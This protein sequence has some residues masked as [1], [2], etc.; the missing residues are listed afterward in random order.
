MN[1]VRLKMNNS[2]LEFIIFGNKTQV[3]KCT[4]EG[5]RIDGEI[6]SRSQIMKYLG[7]CM[8]SELFIKT[9]VKEKCTSAMLNLQRIKNIQ[10]FLTRDSCTKLVVSL[11]LSHLNYSNSK[12]YGL[13]NSTIQQMQNIKNYRAKL[14]LGR[15]KYDSNKEVLAELLWLPIK[16]RIKFKILVLVFKCPGGEAPECLMHLLVRCTEW[17]HSLRSS[18][19][20]ERLVIP[21]TVRQTFALSS[22]SIAGPTLWNRLPNHIKDRNS[23]DIFKK[24]HKTI[25]F[26]NG[27]F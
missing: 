17:T 25:L 18:N 15:G 11:C 12:L 3:N 2:K 4:S 13:P 1:S 27:N 7:A 5:L 16:S 14:V 26:A 24:N 22:F 8:D 6:V 23:L 20:K 9:N 10:K 19:I 21:R